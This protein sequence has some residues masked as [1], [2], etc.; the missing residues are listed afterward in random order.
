M[1]NVTDLVVSV[2]V[3]VIPIIA[4]FFGRK[5]TA[6]KQAV[7]LIQTI[8]PLAKAAVTAAEQLGVTE[9]LTGAAKKSVAVQGVSKS[10]AQMGFTKADKAMVSAAVEK[11]FLDLKAQLHEGRDEHDTTGY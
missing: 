3:A 2:V 1:N 10:L 4:A 7:A 6:S 11:A 5:L 9:Q 8:E